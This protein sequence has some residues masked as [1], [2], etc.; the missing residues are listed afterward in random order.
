MVRERG[1]TRHRDPER[2]R[3]RP[4]SR[5]ARPSSSRAEQRGGDGRDRRLRRRARRLAGDHRGG[6][7]ARLARRR[8]RPSPG[9]STA[10]EVTELSGRGVGLDAVKRY[11][12]WF[13][14]TLEVHSEP[15]NGTAIV[16][17]LPLALALLEV[18]LVERG[19]QRLRAAAREQSRRPS[20][21]RTCSRSRDSSALELRGRV[22]PARRPR[23]SD[24]RDGAPT[25]RRRLRRSS[26]RPAAGGSQRRAIA[27]SARTR[28]SSSRSGR[29]SR[30]RRGYLGA[31]ILGDG[32][33]ALLLDPA[34]L[35]RAS[36]STPRLAPAPAPRVSSASRPRCSSSR[37]RSRCASSSAAFSRPPAIAWR[38]PA[39]A[40]TA[41]TASRPTT[42][43][44]S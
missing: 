17:V 37:T 35:S 25:A 13:G 38:S 3:R 30:R 21:S 10:A 1:R 41:S 24:R 20:P 22:G 15:G 2:D 6:A 18:L 44:S 8:P 7:A 4:E 34:A 40:A 9:F 5:L 28:S 42:R 36:E 11:V 26:S 19:G 33:V 14:G 32:R 29:C 16:L 31:A 12:E 27:C 23:R 43:S 39:T